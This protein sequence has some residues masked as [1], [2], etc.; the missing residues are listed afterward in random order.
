MRK[1]N[2]NLSNLFQ[3]EKKVFRLPQQEQ[4]WLAERIIRRLRKECAD[5]KI[6][7]EGLLAVM[8]ADQ[9]IQTELQKIEEEFAM[10]ESDGL[11]EV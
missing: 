4:L 6:S 7:P 8:A 9:E 10:T 5:D 2:M 1:V 11:E 3:I